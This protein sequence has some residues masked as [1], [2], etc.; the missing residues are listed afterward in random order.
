MILPKYLVHALLY[1][2]DSFLGHRPL[3]HLRENVS[4]RS[5]W[6]DIHYAKELRRSFEGLIARIIAKL[7][8][9]R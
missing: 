1:C 9:A 4:Q 3:V 6:V 5:L 7:G 2:R 8:L